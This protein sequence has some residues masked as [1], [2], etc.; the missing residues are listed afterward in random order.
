[1]MGLPGTGKTFVARRLA[2][3][4]GA[5]HFLSDSI[6]KQ[7]L[8][9]P[10]TERRWEGYNKG[11]YRGNI[12]KK[13]YDEMFR[14]AQAFL[15][16]GQRVILDATFL[17]PESR[18]RARAVARRAGVPVRFLFAECPE[19]TVRRRLVRRDIETSFSDANLEVYL[20]M[21]RKFA[22]P[23]TERDIL[24]INTRQPVARLVQRI[25]RALLPL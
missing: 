17:H 23:R 18:E 5:F 4:T 12:G 15:G 1:M 9:I 19:P 11:I 22:P 13:T 6:R 14:R 21:K 8:G 25:E 7:L 16:A 24:R 10:V 3:R 20:A 2:A